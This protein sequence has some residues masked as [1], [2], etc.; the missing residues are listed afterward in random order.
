MSRKFALMK[1]CYEEGFNLYKKKNIT[2][3][4]GVTVL[5][6]CNGI[7]KTTLLHQIRD[8][9]KKMIY[10]ILSLTICVMVAVNLHRKPDF[11]ETLNLWQQLY[12]HPK[13][14]IL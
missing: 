5:V 6:G 4:S 7:G 2:I 10:L 11:M 13:V 1:D 8:R 12:V 3:E 9:L 14:K